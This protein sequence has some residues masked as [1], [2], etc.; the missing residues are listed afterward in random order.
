LTALAERLS[1]PV[2]QE[3]FGAQAG[4]PQDHPLFAGHLPARRAR[5][6]ETLTPHDAVL[7]IGTGALRQYPYDAGPLFHPD[8]RVAVV[9][10]DPEEVHRSPVELGVLGDPAAICAALAEA[11]EPR[12]PAPLPRKTT[13][14]RASAPV[15]DRKQPLRAAHVLDALAER[16]PRDT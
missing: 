10:Q 8:T 7:I 15:P 14:T 3:P 6:R 5:L 9:S 13:T 4:F 1:C 12:T 16:L 11:I 2:F